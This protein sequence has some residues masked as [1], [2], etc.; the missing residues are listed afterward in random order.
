MNTLFKKL[1][2]VSL[3]SITT[4]MPS[5]AAIEIDEKDFGPTY[6]S[7]VADAVAGKPLGLLAVAGGTAAFVVSLPFT[8]F[9]GDVLQARRKLI[10][11][12]AMALDRCLGCTPAQDDDYKAK[13][14]GHG[15]VRVLVDGPSEILINTNQNV[16]V[17]TP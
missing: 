7:A 17:H 9:T 4:I 10:E 14:D 16:V 8:I 1:A 15:Q 5:F 6:G 11:E 13:R 12:P 2:F 3:L